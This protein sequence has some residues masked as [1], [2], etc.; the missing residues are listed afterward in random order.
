M[1]RIGGE[2]L[3]D[4]TRVKKEVK[5]LFGGKYNESKWVRPK[6]DVV[7]FKCLGEVDVNAKI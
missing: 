3:E 5:N 6:L 7:D 4:P 1:L 2:W